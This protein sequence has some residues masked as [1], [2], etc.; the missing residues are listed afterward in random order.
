M[1]F[2]VDRIECSVELS[3]RQ[4]DKLDNLDYLDFINPTLEKLGAGDIEY[5][6][7]FGQRIM[8]CCDDH[9]QATQIVN[10]IEEILK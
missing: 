3:N 1:D 7:H 2:T 4:W 8:F 9:Q 6:G 5:N 10:K